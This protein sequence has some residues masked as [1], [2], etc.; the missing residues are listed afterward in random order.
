MDHGTDSTEIRSPW[1]E[2][3]L[4]LKKNR[5]S[6]AGFIVFTLI[7]LLCLAAPLISLHD[8]NEM[9]MVYG[10]K[11]PTTEHW[12]GT[13]THGRDLFARTLH[14]GRISIAVG[15]ASTVVALTIGIAWGSTAGFIGGWLDAIM[16][17]I[18]DIL[19]SLPFII[20]VILLM[21]LFERSMLLLF[22]AIGFVEWL[23]LARI[24][25]GQIV[26]LKTMPYIEAASCL[27]VHPVAIVFKHLVPN[28]IGP[29]IVYA[30]LTVPAVMLLESALSFLGLG[31][32]PPDSSW[33]S[34]INDGAEKIKSYPWLLVFPS[35]F[36]STTLFALNFIGDGLRDALDPKSSN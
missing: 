23:T 34:L 28:L 30:T 32:Q 15:F 4:R 31:V 26:H 14:G 33:G 1:E 12:F 17:R 6:V 35:I 16:M 27:G 3:W 24:V 11:A 2:S 5:L 13:D 20:F 8:P 36:F 25:R 7:T 29:V 10:P 21:T 22:I 19:Y 9:N 18:V